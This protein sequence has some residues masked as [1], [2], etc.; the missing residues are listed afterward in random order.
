MSHTK[1]AR[2]HCLA[3]EI[4]HRLHEAHHE[5]LFAGGCV[6]DQLLG[7]PPHD[8]DIVTD[9]HPDQIQT[10]FERT[11]PVGAQ[12]GVILV[13]QES[14]PFQIATFRR[15]G[16]YLDH[17]HPEKVSFGGREEDA[18]RRDF[19]IN[20]LFE[21][22]LKGSILDYVGGQKD[23]HDRVIRCIGDPATR[24]EEDRLRLLRAIRFATILNFEIHPDTWQAVIARSHLLSQISAER[25]REELCRILLSPQRTRG[26]DLLDQSGILKHLL[27]EVE[28]LKGCEQPVEFHPEGDVFVHT[29]L[30]LSLLPPKVSL[31]LVL[32]VLFHD[33]GKPGTARV[34]ETGRIRFNAHEKL[35]AEMTVQIMK[36]L[37]YSNSEIEKTEAIVR[38][39]MS[40]KDVKNMRRS[41]LKRFLARPAFE[42]ELELHRV[43]C[44]GSHGLLDNYEFLVA[45][46]QELSTEVLVP[47]ALLTGRDLIALGW[48]PGP[49]F[50][51][52][53]EAAHNAQLEGI[54]SS[55]QEAI[56]FV[57]KK[58]P[59][60][61][62]DL[63][64]K[65]GD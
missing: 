52:A 3:L 55:K 24:F 43:D 4:V 36:R 29:R 40:F 38:N 35:S 19:T 20:G 30:M 18:L 63:Q 46:R 11:V 59:P 50:K 58:Y 27:P 48:K 64:L 2:L 37:R 54:L 62:S 49:Q 33:L 47:P 31:P 53:L 41:T 42:D 25:I 10:L 12:F 15:D 6:R 26:F 28:A 23:L 60:A 9:A 34:D 22:P 61:S 16:R 44:L 51:I 14:I 5:A 8:Y 39:H 45:K 65:I 32:A 1:T 13:I 21:D 57:T 17:R 56:A 7:T